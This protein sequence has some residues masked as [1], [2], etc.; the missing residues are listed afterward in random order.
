MT[1]TFGFPQSDWEVARGEAH[2]LMVA[3]ARSA[4]G[5]I[6][7]SDL[8][9]KIEAIS[10]EP[11]SHI[12]HEL[13]SQISQAENEAGRGMLGVVVVHK[14]GDKRGQP[15]DG[16]FKLARELGRNVRDPMKCWASELEHVR[17]AWRQKP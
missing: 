8:A 11:D 5:R 7:Y 3:A 15:G 12:F 1:R 4:A 10:F 13:L 17:A 6:T 9:S 2:A 14:S 16:F